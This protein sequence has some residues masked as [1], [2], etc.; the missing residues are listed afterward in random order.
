MTL[1]IGF[2]IGAVACFL[3]LKQEE[4]HSLYL[5][6]RTRRRYQKLLH[7]TPKQ[8]VSVRCWRDLWQYRHYPIHIEGKTYAIERFLRWHCNDQSQTLIDTEGQPQGQIGQLILD[9]YTDED[10]YMAFIECVGYRPEATAQ[11]KPIQLSVVISV[12]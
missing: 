7:G 8:V 11:L 6:Y 5:S 1:L 4:I 10:R 12:Y 2:I 3:L 9:H